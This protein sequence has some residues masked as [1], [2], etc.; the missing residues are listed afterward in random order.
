MTT[1]TTKKNNVVDSVY[2]RTAGM[3]IQMPFSVNIKGETSFNLFCFRVLRIIPGKRMVC[4]CNYNGIRVVAKFFLNKKKGAAHCLREERGINA[5]KKAGLSTPDIIFKGFI[6]PDGL[7]TLGFQEITPVRDIMDVPEVKKTGMQGSSFIERVVKII[8]KQHEAGL[9]QADIHKENFLLTHDE[10]YSIDGSSVNLRNFG[11]PLSK[12]KS[13]KNLGIFFAQ[14]KPCHD[15]IILPAFNEYASRRSWQKNQ[16]L[17]NCLLKKIKFY[18]KL[19]KKKFLKKIFRESTAFVCKKNMHNYLICNR[20]L[21]T[22]GMARFF[23]DPDA[24]LDKGEILKNGNTSTVALVEMDKKHFVVKRY[25]IKTPWH[26]LKRCLRHTRAYT[27][28]RNSN[29]LIFYD[30]LTPRPV[31]FYEKRFGPLRSTAYFIMEHIDGIDAMTFFQPKNIKTCGAKKIVQRF[32][33][34]FKSLADRSISHGDFKATN[35]IIKNGKIY[36][37]DLDGMQEHRFKWRFK[38]AF[39][40]DCRRMIKNWSNDPQIAGQISGQL[41]EILR[42]SLSQ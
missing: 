4:L 32:G 28:W 34:L 40:K 17:Y 16:K 15:N 12:A 9:F 30:I 8:A 19:R 1:K 21:Y 20:E 7:P 29:M 39:N 14:F 22:K 27:S 18:R 3:D 6:D 36:V 13:L 24:L 10:V 38:R 5:L 26:A 11:R 23:N 25:N 2:L 33:D 31:A 37:I 35:F 42:I 41:S